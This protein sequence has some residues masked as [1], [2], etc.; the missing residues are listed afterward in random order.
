MK[1]TVLK[2]DGSEELFYA[3]NME[4]QGPKLLFF[5]THLDGET[6]VLDLGDEQH[7]KV[8]RVD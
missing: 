6:R 4:A 1:V 7:I 2:G 8:E 5:P 3:S